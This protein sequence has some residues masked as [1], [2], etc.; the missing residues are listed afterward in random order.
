MPEN[1][2]HTPDGAPLTLKDLLNQ[3][4]KLARDSRIPFSTGKGFDFIPENEILYA[5]AN[6]NYCAL[7]LLDGKKTLVSQSLGEVEGLVSQAIFCRIH[8][9]HL[10]NLRYLERYNSG[11]GGTVILSDGME[12]AVSKGKKSAFLKKVKG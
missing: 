7:F 6:G 1:P 9:S 5:Q 11:E 8:H 12:L 2:N 10:I 4:G 3:F